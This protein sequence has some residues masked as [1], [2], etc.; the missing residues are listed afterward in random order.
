LTFKETR[1]KKNQKKIKKK[2]K[3]EEGILLFILRR[4]NAEE[5][6]FQMARFA[7]YSDGR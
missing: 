5:I 3:R 7:T 6:Q 2:K 4:K 1:W